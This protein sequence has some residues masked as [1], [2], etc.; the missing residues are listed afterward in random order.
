MEKKP[1]IGGIFVYILLIL[2]LL[3]IANTLFNR[4]GNVRTDY[5]DASLKQ[6]I[7]NSEV[8]RV[9]ISQNAEV[10][11]GTVAVIRSKGDLV[12]Y[13]PDVKETVKVLE[14]AKHEVPFT[15]SDV[16]RPSIWMKLMPYIFG[17]I[18]ALIVVF[19]VMA[20]SVGAG[21]GGSTNSKLMFSERAAQRRM[22]RPALPLTM[23][24]DWWKRKKNWQRS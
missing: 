7:S 13:T 3:G 16:E 11:T 17:V 6:D 14:E 20:Q 9:E 23:W 10:P 24:P 22:L 1:K 19:F 21:G 4:K 2:L 15:V 5:T 8:I 12:Y 18:L